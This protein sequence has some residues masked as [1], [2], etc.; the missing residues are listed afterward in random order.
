MK[1]LDILTEK[2]FLKNVHYRIL[3]KDTD[4]VTWPTILKYH[5][6]I[7][8]WPTNHRATFKILV[9]D[10]S[11]SNS[12]WKFYADRSRDKLFFC[13]KK[14]FLTLFSVIVCSTSSFLIITSFF[15]I[16]MAY[17]WLV[18]FSRHKITLPKVPLPKT[19]RNSKFSNVWKKRNKN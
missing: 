12:W 1:K 16:F 13:F 14:Y 11:A 2:G 19:L 8:C 17:S 4:L 18:A 5:I 10:R 15:K 3:A 6:W 9:S 7:E